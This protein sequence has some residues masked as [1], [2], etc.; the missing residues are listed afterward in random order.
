MSPG[1]TP[2]SMSG[3]C[4]TPAG[5]PSGSLWGLPSS[6]DHGLQCEPVQAQLWAGGPCR[7]QHFSTDEAYLEAGLG[8]GHRTEADGLGS[9]LPTGAESGEATPEAAGG[10]CA[11]GLVRRG[12][13]TRPGPQWTG[14]GAGACHPG[15]SGP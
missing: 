14:L 7:P 6:E 3:W 11:P 2:P 8:R 13:S 9:L 4:P 15:R 10:L 5:R 1:H 12:F